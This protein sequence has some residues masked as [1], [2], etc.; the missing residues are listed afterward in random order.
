MRV[1]GNNLERI[2]EATTPP[3]F[4][5][6]Q[7]MPRIV[8]CLVTLVGLALTGLGAGWA[9]HDTQLDN[10]QR[11]DRLVERMRGELVRRVIV[12]RYG[13][14]GTRSVFAASDQVNRREFRRLVAA[15]ELSTEF[16]GALGIGYIERVRDRPEAI[17]QFVEQTRADGAPGFSITV[18]PGAEPMPGSVID[19]RMIIKYIMPLDRNRTALGLDIGAHPVRREA[20]ERAML[21]ADGCITGRIDLVQEDKPVAGFLYLL[22]W[23]R[24]GMP[25]TTRQQRIDALVGW[26]YMPMLGPDVFDGVVGTTHRE[27]EV[28]IYDGQVADSTLIYKSTDEP[29]NLRRNRSHGLLNLS[30]IHVGGREWTAKTYASPGFKYAPM[31]GVWSIAVGGACL[32]LLLGVIV[33]N[34]GTATRRAHALAQ[35]M[36]VE[37]RRYAAEAHAAT[38][39][40]SEFLA[41]MSHEIR[42]PMT[43]ILGF[44]DILEETLPGNSDCHEHLGTIRRNGKHLL[45]IINDILDLS[46]IEAGKL[47]LELVD[48]PLPQLLRDV[49]TLMQPR[50]DAA[51]IALNLNHL[52]AVPVRVRTDAVRLRQI[53]VNLVSNAVKFTS[54]GAV[55]IDVSCDP[56]AQTLQV[57]VRDTGCGMT[58]QQQDQLFKAFQQADASISRKYGGTGLGLHISQRLAHMLEGDITVQSTPGKGSRFTLTL[59][60]SHAEQAAMIEPETGRVTRA[61]LTD[62]PSVKPTVPDEHPLTGMNILVAE[63]SIDVQRLIRMI[64]Q[65]AGA[66]VTVVDNGRAVIEALTIDGTTDSPLRHPPPFDLV[67]TDMQMPELDGYSAVRQ[68]RDMGCTLRILALTAHAMS[69]DQRKCLE[70][71]CDGYLVKPVVRDQ[72]INACRS[73]V[74]IH[75]MSV[76]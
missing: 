25:L 40:K 1:D 4:N 68:L 7:H 5:T 23:Y 53:L 56:R 15:R 76:A 64:L 62:S 39:S 3:F 31:T 43:A 57:A 32:S 50:A 10:H 2:N 47:Q 36:T 33:F 46:K 29:I 26:V 16:P 63:D 52:T 13:M 20:A 60:C 8:A 44:T 48:T 21:T 14:M 9:Y 59:P 27:L 72:L 65:R 11:F 28:A 69:G 54:E 70:V 6:Q 34:M 58:Q 37:L 19:D 45:T 73:S 38:R 55:D 49:Y 35:Q 61:C 18:P 22:P 75:E 42:T 24:P 74:G 41:N 67:I 17:E 30:T 71:G 12:Y 51:G 66:H